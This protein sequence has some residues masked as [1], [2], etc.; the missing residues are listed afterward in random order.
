MISSCSSLQKGHRY[1]LPECNAAASCLHDAHHICCS[2]QHCSAACA[3]QGEWCCCAAPNL[4]AMPYAHRIVGHFV[5]A[6]LC[7][8]I[9]ADRTGQCPYST[10]PG[11][12]TPHQGW[13]A[14]PAVLQ[15][16]LHTAAGPNPAMPLFLLSL[17]SYLCVVQAWL[18]V[19]TAA[20]CM[21]SCG[22]QS[23]S[24]VT[25]LKPYNMPASNNERPSQHQNPDKDQI[26][27]QT[28]PKTRATSKQSYQLAAHACWQETATAE[29][30][31]PYGTDTPKHTLQTFPSPA[32]VC[33]GEC[34]AAAATHSCPST[35]ARHC[36]VKSSWY[37]ACAVLCLSRL[38]NPPSCQAV[39]PRDRSARPSV[40]Q[41][42]A[43]ALNHKLTHQPTSHSARLLPNTPTPAGCS[44]APQRTI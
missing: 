36:S 8:Y 20:A 2:T 27:S 40:P 29:P 7:P 12:H 19:G 3:V 17:S 42:S 24:L 21:H 10:W 38:P 43:S 26:V 9:E 28:R 33:R 13:K 11:Q 44:V 18:W 34:Q 25:P 6:E 14:V 30:T 4:T 22:V 23:C 1:C 15:P 31:Q 41:Q 35:Q 16:M 39:K 32:P 37:T 5:C